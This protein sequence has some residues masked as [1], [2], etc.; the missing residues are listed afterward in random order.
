MGFSVRYSASFLFLYHLADIL[1]GDVM[2]VTL[3]GGPMIVL[4]TLKATKDL[5]DKRGSI[6]SDRPRMVLHM[7][8]YVLAWRSRRSV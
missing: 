4:N 2:L 3:P 6:Y 5:L 1:A 7:E 8:M